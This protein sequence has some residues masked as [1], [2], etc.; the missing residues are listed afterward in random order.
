MTRFLTTV[1]AI[2]LTTSAASAGGIDRSGQPIGVIFEDGT[3][4]E[5]SLGY[6]APDVSGTAVASLGGFPSGDMAGDYFSLG[7]AVKHE[8][9]NG[10]EVALIWDQPFGANVDYPTGTN[11]FAQGSNADLTTQAITGLVRM[12]L[13]ENMSIHGGVRY[14]TMKAD[15]VV[16]FVDNY[17]AT[18]DQAAGI[19]YVLGAAY[20]IPEI[21]LRVALTYN[22]KVTHD[23]DV[24]ETTG[25]FGTRASTLEVETP[26]SVNLDF[27]TGVAAD[28]LLFGSVRWVNWSNFD[29]SPNDYGIVTS[30]GSLVSYD[31]DSV[32]YS[33]GLGRRLNEKF[34]VAATLGYEASTGGFSSNLGPTD[35]YWNAGLGG[36]YTQDNMKISGGL[37]YV[38]IGDAQTTLN[39]TD[40]ASNFQDNSAIGVGVKVGLSF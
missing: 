33:L 23:H 6:A 34:S 7:A 28:T 16:P 25:T 21:A 27:Q 12:S 1:S 17:S 32:S 20:E 2:A 37:R 14:Q 13:D 35:G 9:S 24:T 29:I 4:A 8:Y 18:A 19:G 22:S 11:Y 39:G 3:Y 5:F 31:D 36:T 15:A 38:S 40:A 10:L 30:G 26:Q